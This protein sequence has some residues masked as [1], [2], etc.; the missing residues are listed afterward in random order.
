MAGSQPLSAP[1]PRAMVRRQTSPAGP[2]LTFDADFMPQRKRP[3]RSRDKS[4]SR[5]RSRKPNPN[6]N[7]INKPETVRHAVFLLVEAHRIQ[8]KLVRDLLTTMRIP[9]ELKPQAGAW[10]ERLIVRRRTIDHILKKCIA[11]PADQVQEQL[12]TLLQMGASELLFGPTDVQHAAIDETVELCRLL[13]HDNWT[14]FANGVLRGVQRL[15]S[16]EV[17][18]KPS[19]RAYPLTAKEYRVLQEDIFP[20][21]AENLTQYAGIAFSLSDPI[22]REWSRRYEPDVLLTLCGATLRPAPMSVRVNRLAVEPEEWLKKCQTQGIEVTPTEF[23][24]SYL[25]ETRT[26]LSDLPGFAEGEFVV[27]DSTATMAARMLNPYPGGRVLDL[28]AGPGTKTTQLAELMLDRGELVACEVAPH[29]IEQIEDNIRRL[30]LTCIQTHQIE[31]NS[32]EIPGE[33]FEA[34]LVDAPCSN[35]GVLGKR[36]EARWR[37]SIPELHLLNELQMQLL[38]SAASYTTEDGRIVYSTCSIEPKENEGLVTR[39]LEQ[40]PEF[41]CTDMAHRLPDGQRDGGFCAR[42]E[43]IE[44]ETDE[45]TPPESTDGE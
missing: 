6:Q 23:A 13:D 40:H 9:D 18:D 4:R 33:P 42:L 12:W 44:V 22:L 7:R 1:A 30:N 28:C 11:R 21:P 41:R 38:D 26:R 27:Q 16:E 35:T 8:K 19:A 15:M 45:E 10:A 17:S 14:Q 2:T 5:S 36:P 29:R 43:R 34:I 3:F 20:D 37:Y 24:G 39:W 32:P 31:R 25:I